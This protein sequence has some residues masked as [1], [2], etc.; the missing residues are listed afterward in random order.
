M[1]GP[2]Q[3]TSVSV[4]FFIPSPQL[5][6]LQMSGFPDVS[7]IPLWQSL[8]STHFKPLAHGPQVVPP[9]SL[10]VS[11]GSSILFWQEFG[12]HCPLLQT[13][14][15]MQSETLLHFCPSAQRGHPAAVPPQSTSLSFPFLTPSAGLQVGAMHRHGGAGQLFPVPQTPLVQSPGTAQFM[16]SAHFLPGAQ[17]PPQSTLVS[18]PFFTESPQLGAWQLHGGAGQLFITPHTPLWQSPPQLHGRDTSQRAQGPSPAAQ[19]VVPPPQSISDSV[20]FF[21]T[22]KQ[23]GA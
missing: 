14:V 18:V 16:P 17:L 21:T 1:S 11:P 22:S 10:S 6:A 15:A 20:P 8:G 7:Q 9:Q 4:P 12:P 3:S 23:V 5:G 2:P 19:L 13:W